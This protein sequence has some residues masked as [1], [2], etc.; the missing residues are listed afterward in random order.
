MRITS[1]SI[2]IYIYIYMPLRKYPNMDSVHYETVMQL[3]R[4]DLIGFFLL[5]TADKVVY[6]GILSCCSYLE[7][8]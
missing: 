2:D 7:F 5:L 6:T 3:N 1:E 4:P 8:E